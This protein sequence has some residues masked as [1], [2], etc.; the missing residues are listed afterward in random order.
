[1]LTQTDSGAARSFSA[2]TMPSMACCSSGATSGSFTFNKVHNIHNEKLEMVSSA[3]LVANIRETTCEVTYW[4][5][6][7]AMG[8]SP[9]WQGCSRQWVCAISMHAC[10]HLL[11][12]I[13]R[14]PRRDD[15]AQD[16]NV[17]AWLSRWSGVGVRVT[18]RVRG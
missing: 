12:S 18:D 15:V 6:C 10:T 3:S 5:G 16:G 2:R 14:E 9:Q 11:Y 17:R 4:Q 8:V 1:M 13:A 7:L